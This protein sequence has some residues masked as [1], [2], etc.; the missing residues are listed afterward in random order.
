MPPKKKPVEQ[1]AKEIIDDIV[2]VKNE[3]KPEKVK[4]KKEKPKKEKPEKKRT[5]RGDCNMEKP[6]SSFK[7]RSA[8][9]N[10][11]IEDNKNKEYP[12]RDDGQKECKGIC[13]K[14]KD[15]T[16]FSG[17]KEETDGCQTRC[18]FC[19][20]KS[21][22]ESR[23]K[24]KNKVAIIPS[25]KIC[26]NE[27][28]ELANVPQPSSNFTKDK[29]NKTDGLYSYCKK[30]KHGRK[31]EKAKEYENLDPEKDTKICKHE[32]CGKTKLL[33]EFDV[34]MGNDCNRANICKD[35]RHNDRLLQDNK[36]PTE[37]THMCCRCKED[38]N[39]SEFDGSRHNSFGLQSRCKICQKE[40]EQEYRATFIGNIENLFKDI[41]TNANNK[42]EGRIVPVEITQDDIK[43]MYAKQKGFCSLTGV[44][45]THDA[46]GRGEDKEHNFNK[47]NMSVDRIDS[48]KAYTKDNTHLTTAI[49]NRMKFTHTSE[50]YKKM[51]EKI[52]KYDSL[53]VKQK[54]KQKVS[55][56]NPNK[57]SDEDVKSM[58]KKRVRDMK[59]NAKKSKNPKI[60]EINEDDILEIYKTQKGFCNVSGEHLKCVVGDE[61]SLSIDRIDSSKGY[62]KDNVQLVTVIINRCKNDYSMKDFVDTC[63]LVVAHSK[64]PKQ[65]NDD[66]DFE[67]FIKEEVGDEED[68]DNG[69]DNGYDNDDGEEGDDNGDEVDDD[70]DNEYE[71]DSDIE[72]Y[73]NEQLAMMN[74][75]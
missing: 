32:D 37:G 51:C 46:K 54:Q 69:Y 11:C 50:S 18:K 16:E 67:K 47:N 43:D 6:V 73:L 55:Q 2:E 8:Y 70:N 7:L 74:S 64:E 65:D 21:T 49:S 26:S 14:T 5:C 58:I 60:V 40:V 38:K 68:N 22:E 17:C 24:N 57:N 25:T 28:C 66:I 72:D 41:K 36:K 23:E 10:E 71:D 62:T 52:E 53:T 75:K 44:K 9:C 4:S 13:G 63:K 45:M 31:K 27:N 39:V 48:S 34:Q 20:R 35:C 19:Q 29:G 56:I 61:N 12:K 15:R 30:C 33:R 1:A 59:D 42:K 3:E